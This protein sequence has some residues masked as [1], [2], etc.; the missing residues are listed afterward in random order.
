MRI[1]R[2]WA[3]GRGFTPGPR[4]TRSKTYPLNENVEA[5]TI[6]SRKS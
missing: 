6:Y 5:L 2:C 3:C 1:Y 4:A